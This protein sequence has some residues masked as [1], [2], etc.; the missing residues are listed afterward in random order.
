MF[1]KTKIA[2]LTSIFLWASAFV[3][4]RAGLQDYS[5]EG[6]A[7]LRF[8]V[9]SVCMGIVYFRLPERS[10][11][12]WRD[13]FA[14]MCL[15]MLGIGV[16]NI[17]LNYGELSVS[18]G[19]ASFII[20]QSPII[21]ALIAIPFLGERLTSMRLLG[22]TVSVLGVAL[23]MMGQQGEEL[24][25]DIG[26][27]YVLIAA[28]AGSIFSVLQKPF[29]KRYHAIEAT[30]YAMWGGTLFLAINTPKLLHDLPQAS[31]SSTLTVIYLGIFPAAVG[32]IA[33][34]YALK[35]LPASRVMSF[36]Y[37]IP[38]L[39]TLL[40][41]LLLGEVPTL[42]SMTGGLIAIAGVWF[43]NHSYRMPVVIQRPVEDIA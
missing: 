33:W 31:L 8:I 5:P 38:F 12:R 1:Q 17:T 39:A 22:F 15:G 35:A 20:S 26:V 18:S 32:Y 41:W 25:W 3:G 40:G 30:T 14:M 4:I 10:A 34:S 24:N 27:V 42:L 7:L 29:L 19:V 43:V 2:V 37:F 6:L 11:I 23:I 36:L 16:Y 13:A 21:A 28:C 9:A